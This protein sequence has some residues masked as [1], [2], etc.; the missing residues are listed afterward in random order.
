MYDEDLRIMQWNP[1]G[2][3]GMWTILGLE[4]LS[5]RRCAKGSG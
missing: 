5:F 3:A 1:S 2:K 4:N